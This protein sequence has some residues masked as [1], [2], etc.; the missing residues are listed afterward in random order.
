M[1]NNKIKLNWQAFPMALIVLSIFLVVGFVAHVWHPT[2]LIFFAIPLYHWGVDVIQHKR[3]KGLPVFIAVIVSLVAF[4]LVGFV[5]DIWHPTWL[6]F[7]LIPITA[8]MEGF[9]SGGIRGQVQKA[10]KKIKDSII[11]ESDEDDDDDD[12]DEGTKA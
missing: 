3:I 1:D 2:W 9:L 6:V 5:W 11:Y 12:D 8:A 4:L 10:G 7:L